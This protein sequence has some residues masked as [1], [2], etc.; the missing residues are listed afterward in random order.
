MAVQSIKPMPDLTADI[1]QCSESEP[2]SDRCLNPLCDKP[3]APKK[4]HAPIK[5]YC[6][7]ACVQ[8]ASI[9]KRAGALVAELDRSEVLRIMGK[10]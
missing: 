5:L 1:T 9:L 3:M 2:N 10:S 6:S 4:K 7:A 8:S